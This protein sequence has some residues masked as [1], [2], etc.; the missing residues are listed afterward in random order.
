MKKFLIF[1]INK[2]IHSTSRVTSEL[3]KINASYDFIKWS[4]LIFI[5]GTPMADG[6]IIH[7]KTYSAAFYDIPSYYLLLDKKTGARTAFD[8]DNELDVVLKKIKT[9]N[10]PA[11]NRDFLIKHPFYNK[12]TQ[13]DIFNRKKITSIPTLHLNDNKYEKALAALRLAGFKFPLVIKESGGGLGEQVWK[14]ENDNALKNFLK[15]R[16]NT[17]LIYQP[18]I[19]NSGDFRVLVIGKKSV[20]IMKRSA[21]KNEWRNNF[22]L[23]GK[24]SAY[25]DP[26]MERF[27]ENVCAK[28]EMDYAGVDILKTRTG[29]VVIEVNSFARFEGFEKTHP[30]KN[31]GALIVKYLSSKK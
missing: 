19:K 2:K 13:S 23:G 16:R 14:I 5:D 6:K 1:G 11:M 30:D 18:F 4:S 28:M 25:K 29:Y 20:G 3:E 17:S 27:A 15:T 24:V 31:I 21:Q 8:L 9:A 12:F 10:L 7:L 22:A 26:K